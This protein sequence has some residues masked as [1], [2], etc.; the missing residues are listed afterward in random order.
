M[1]IC[2]VGLNH[3]GDEQYA[4]QY[5]DAVLKSRA[6][7]V[8]FQVLKDSFYENERF[9]KF[10]L[11]EEFLMRASQRIKSGHKHFG[12]ALDDEGAIDFLE[13]QD[14]AFYKVLS[15]D[16]H[17]FDLIDRLIENTKRKIFVSTGMSDM[18][19]IDLL[20]ERIKSVK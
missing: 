19:E 3:L 16:I 14:V 10:Q 9:K 20:F 8:T 4:D 17:N 6:D 1:I 13:S 2:E 12:A 18:G 11:G 7:A 5:I 15:K